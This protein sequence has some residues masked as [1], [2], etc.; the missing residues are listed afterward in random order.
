MAGRLSLEFVSSATRSSDL[1][2]LDVPEIAVVGRSNVGKSSLINSLARRRDLAKVSKTPGRTQLLNYFT[3]RDPQR[4]VTV[5]GF[6]DL[7]GYGFAKVPHNVRQKWQRMIEDY[8]LERDQLSMVLVLVDAAVGPTDLDVMM[9]DWL[10]ANAL[11]HQV[12]AT[13]YDKVKSSQRSKRKSQL[14]EGCMLEPGDIT[15]TSTAKNIGIDVLWSRVS[16][17]LELDR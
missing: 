11:P 17:W 3:L 6:V 14:A 9:L 7:P 5:G 13:K 15:W 1:P 10:R 4:G 2:D 16:G 8:L 12:V